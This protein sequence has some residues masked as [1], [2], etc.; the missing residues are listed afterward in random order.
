[1]ANSTVRNFVFSTVLLFLS[2]L[3]TASFAEEVDAG[4][5][6]PAIGGASIGNSGGAIGSAAEEPSADLAEP[7]PD[8]AQSEAEQAPAEAIEPEAAQQLEAQPEAALATTQS[9]SSVL[10]PADRI[11]GDL[12][13][14]AVPRTDRNDGALRYDI[15]IDAPSFR[16]LEPR[17]SLHYNSSR[18]TRLGGTYQG[19]LGY[20]WGIEGFDVIERASVGRGLPAYDSN[21]VYLLNGVELVACG[22]ETVSPSCATGGTHATEIESYRR[23][24]RNTTSNIWKVTDADGTVSS[25]EP[26]S[27]FT[28]ISV[29]AGTPAHRVTSLYRW[30]LTSV[31]DRHG[32]TVSYSYACPGISSSPLTAV[33]YPNTVIYNGTKITFHREARPDAILMANGYDI[34]SVGQRIATISVRVG[35]V[36]RSAYELTYDQAPFSNASRLRRVDVHG[37]NAQVA[38][39]G[40]ITP[41][42]SGPGKRRI[43]AFTYQ[44][45]ANSY[46]LKTNPN[47]TP[48]GGL[49]AGANWSGRPE[50]VDDLNLDGRDE[51]HG[52]TF[53]TQ[54]IAGSHLALRAQLT[55]VRFSPE[56]S[57]IDAGHN[58]VVSYA[59]GQSDAHVPSLGIQHGRINPSKK[60]KDFITTVSTRQIFH[61]SNGQEY[62]FGSVSRVFSSNADLVLTQTCNG[63]YAEICALVPDVAPT[64]DPDPSILRPPVFVDFD[65]DTVE[66]AHQV[67]ASLQNGLDHADFQ[68]NGQQ[69]YLASNGRKALW[70]GTAWSYSGDAYTLD[71]R[72]EVYNHTQSAMHN[73]CVFADVN[74]D[75]AMDVIAGRRITSAT[76]QDFDFAPVIHLS[77][78][79]SFKRLTLSTQIGGRLMLRDYD[80]DGKADF[81]TLDGWDAANE[82][83]WRYGTLRA[84]SLRTGSTNT[85]ELVT[86]FSGTRGLTAGDFNGDGLPD[87]F[88][89][90]ERHSLYVSN[91]G[92]GNPN[93][94]RSVVNE[95]GAT[96]TIDYTPSTRWANDFL[97]QVL[98]AVTGVSVDDGRGQV[99]VTSYAY[100]GGKYDAAARK[101]LGYRTI[102]ETKPR[103]NGE[104]GAPTVETTFRQDLASYGLPSLT[105]VND[106]GGVERKRVAETYATHTASKPYRAL[107]TAT[108]TTLT[109]NIAHV[110]RVERTFDAYG[111]V[112]HERDYGRNDANGDG[113]ERMRS[114]EYAPNTSAFIT[115]LPYSDAIRASV[116]TSATPVKSEV[117]FYDGASNAATPPTRG[118]VTR[119]RVRVS[120]DA[121]APVTTYDE[122]F[123]YDPATG[124]LLSSTDGAGNTTS[125]AYQ[126]DY[127]ILPT[128]ER[129]PRFFANGA[130]PAD[131]RHQ[132]FATYNALCDAPATRTDLNGVVHEYTYDAFCRLS[133]YENTTTGYYRAYSYYG[134]GDPEAQYFQVVEPQPGGAGTRYLRQ[135]YDGR[136]R[137]WREQRRGDTAAA[138]VRRIDIDH[139]RR[140]NVARRSQPYFLGD[141]L[142]WTG[143][144][145]DWNDRPLVTTH[146]DGTSRQTSYHHS[147]SLTHTDNVPLGYTRTVDELDRTSYSY[148]STWGDVIRQT[149][150]MEDGANRFQYRSHDALGRLTR[151]RDHGGAEWIYTYDM[152]GNRIAVSDPDLG[153]WS[154]RY[155]AANRM[156]R[157]TDA[158]NTVIGFDYDQLGRLERRWVVSPS[159]AEPDLEVNT[160]DEER[161]GYFNIGRLT[162]ATNATATH[163]VDHHASG[164]EGRRVTTI[165]GQSHTTTTVESLHM[166]T[167]VVYTPHTLNVGTSGAPWNWTANGQLASIPGM[168][169][170]IAYA[171][172]G[173]TQSIDYANGVTTGFT[174]NADRRFLRRINT[175]KPDGTKLLDLTYTRDGAGRIVSIASGGTSSEAWTYAYNNLDWL[176][177]ATHGSGGLSETFTYSATGNLL[178]RS[179]LAEAFT[180]PSGTGTRPHA[181]TKLGTSNITYDANGNMTGDGSRSLSWNAANGCPRWR[182]RAGSPSRSATDRT[183][184]A[185]SSNGR[186]A[187]RSTCPPTSRSTPPGRSPPPRSR[188]IRTWTSRWWAASL[189]GCTATT[190]PRCASSPT[191][192]ATPSRAPAT[193]PMANG[194]A[195]AFR[196]ARAISASAT[197]PKPASPTSTPATTTP[198]SGGSSHRM[199][200][201]RHCRAWGRTDM[202]M[203]GMIPSIR[204][205]RTGIWAREAVAR[206]AWDQAS[207]TSKSDWILPVLFPGT[208]KS[209]IWQMQHSAQYRAT[210]PMRVF[211]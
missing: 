11:Y 100:A 157:Q 164:N 113:D 51:L 49:V 147:A 31:E 159:Q 185:R 124:N 105:I 182:C 66:E 9:D 18:K 75:G 190:S 62:G 128:R 173:Q 70:T 44:N 199:I 63:F 179:R 76:H 169:S 150:T 120:Y 101:F 43:G 187:R 97:P 47:I 108:N 125:F 23:I 12:T 33:C 186:S 207:T 170:S 96:A 198:C 7:S 88:H 95:L 86:T 204:A 191:R 55:T 184:P 28:S 8:E 146:A 16:G 37:S 206:D 107:N 144:T 38:S 32:N 189:T 192:P 154:Y 188:A 194:R 6:G 81:L 109:E 127:K 34:S 129:N 119:K 136:G 78:G 123:S 92:D 90:T 138:P 171:A 72:Y 172:D 65:G 153:D 122:E 181:P 166:T 13:R 25:F 2:S 104:P 80:N 69:R 19:W 151:V 160:Y 29:E 74:G 126:D 21:D 131:T 77:T 50:A 98:H 195:A 183:A 14:V 137:V 134:D 180:Y 93:L 35:S 45:A 112:V 83:W 133:R 168:I 205:M 167:R 41:A 121:G 52:T 106:G 203:R 27:R 209:L 58:H 59:L 148:V 163:S 158:R 135:S 208:A 210:G 142:A 117:Y 17:I 57:A 39:D 155:N 94:L 103:A 20:G 10:P 193:P 82:D 79:R 46:L 161:A 141:A 176:M 177:S 140:G 200:G 85:L 61:T 91:P 73:R 1:V 114:R 15:A 149:T 30:Y 54:T 139:D 130:D 116:S 22:E 152:A 89:G 84:H 87:F 53:V 115:A 165:D 42:A 175:R 201:T 102:T 36:L 211:R 178:T 48:P 143:I 3:Y 132:T 174:Y 196:P 202:R 40:T 197:T 5:A 156:I 118:S 60:T 4:T 71:C 68:G 26:P 64:L 67:T 99:A 56:G 24:S 110:L 111:N 162:T 145:Y